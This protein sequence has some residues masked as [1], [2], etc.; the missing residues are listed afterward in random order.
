MILRSSIKERLR[1][2]GDEQSGVEQGGSVDTNAAE[3]PAILRSR[4]LERPPELRNRI[5]RFALVNDEPVQL[6]GAAC[7]QP[8]LLKAGRQ[9]RREA[10]SIYYSDNTFRIKI[11]DMDGIAMIPFRKLMVRYRFKAVKG[12]FIFY[13]T[14]ARNWTNLL[15]WLKAHHHD[16]KLACGRVNQDGDAGAVS[17]VVV[18]AFCIAGALKHRRWERVEEVLE[19]YHKGIAAL[20]AAWT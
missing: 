19:A 2:S 1:Q 12:N 16:S 10:I 17:T 15:A 8:A 3:N 6:L 20:D 5:Y 7:E 9:L 11:R 14:Y 13:T 18:Q 4:F